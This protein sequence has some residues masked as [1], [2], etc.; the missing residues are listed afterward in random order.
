MSPIVPPRSARA[1]VLLSAAVA[2]IAGCAA[3]ASPVASTPSPTT[4]LAPAPTSTP[5]PSAPPTVPAGL[6][7]VASRG[8]IV[9]DTAGETLV[10][11]PFSTAPTVAIDQISDALGENP[12]ALIEPADSCLDETTVTRWGGLRLDTPP[13]FAAIDSAQFTAGAD[14]PE[15]GG[16]VPI[17]AGPGF[18]VDEPISS[19]SSLAS[20]RT[21]DGGSFVSI[22]AELNG[23]SFDDPEAWGIRG[24]ATGGV[25]EQFGAPLYY[26]YDC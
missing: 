4:T 9:V 22:V 8:V 3:P 19:V 21:I 20:V 1:V 2:V 24:F 11:V 25:I 10:E 6:V 5:T 23:S 26:Y 14:G 16:G 13:S 17:I 15:T 12:T 18:A 7:I